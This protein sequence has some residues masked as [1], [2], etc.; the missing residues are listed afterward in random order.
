MNPPVVQ[1]GNTYETRCEV[2]PTRKRIG[3]LR[4]T[5][6]LQFLSTIT[7]SSAPPTS[8]LAGRAKVD[9]RFPCT[10]TNG[11]TGTRSGL[12]QRDRVRL[13]D[14]PAVTV[15]VED[16]VYT[17]T[18]GRNDC[19]LDFVGGLVTVT[20]EDLTV[21]LGR[22]DRDRVAVAVA[23]HNGQPSSGFWA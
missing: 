16:K 15:T 21:R 6:Q 18:V 22:K 7:V 20:V 1:N 12:T 14:I 2:G 8:A 23:V 9:I 4:G 13:M 19:E 3:T 5:E 11:G 10:F 17:V